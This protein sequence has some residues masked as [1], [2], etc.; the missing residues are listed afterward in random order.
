MHTEVASGK[1]DLFNITGNATGSFRL[2]VQDSGV[3]P[4]SDDSLLLVKTRG[5][6]AAFI[7]TIYGMYR[8]YGQ[9]PEICPF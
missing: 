4:T 8:F 6:D 3:S 5:G 9:R 2:F 7:L 1:G